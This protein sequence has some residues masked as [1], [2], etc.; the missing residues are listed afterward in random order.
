M[1]HDAHAPTRIEGRI[2]TADPAR[3]WAASVEW[4]DGAVVAVDAPP[5]PGART[6]RLPPAHVALPGLIDAHLHLTLGALTLAQ[7]DL[8]RVRSRAEFERAVADA[9]R[10]LAPG[11]WLRAH[12]WHEANW[13]GER[14]TRAWLAGA[15]DVPCVAYRMDHHACVVN[16]PVL[17]RIA[18]V[19][20]PEGGEVVR[21]AGGAPTGL[22]LEQAAW[23]LV[24]P[25]VPEPPAADRREA[26]LRAHAHCNAFGITAVGSMEYE[27]DLREVHVPLGERLGAARTLR[28]LATILDRDW[29]VDRAWG[30]ALRPDGHLRVAGWKQFIDGTLGSRTAR[31]LEPYSDDAG[32]RG[33]LVETAAE[34]R[35]RLREWARETV[36]LG[37][38][39]SMH[40]IGDEAMRVALDAVD[41]VDPARVAR[42]EHCQTLD[43]ADLA[44][45]RGRVASMQPLHKADDAR[46]AHA[47]L[48]EARMRSFFRFRDL[49]DAGARLAFGSD[50]PIVSCDPRL[51]IRAAVTGLDLDGRP[52]RIDQN[53]TVGESLAAYTRGAAD[54]LRAPDL[55]MLAPGRAADLCVLAAD[56]FA[57]DW[58]GG[59][60]PAVA[61]TVVAGRE[62]HG[63]LA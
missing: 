15:G 16:D 61:A 19:P 24:N 44:R 58:H 23:R 34:S 35:D 42:F 2:W 50:W 59:A 18:G 17:A 7:L 29:P 63:A 43:D 21:D 31:M 1:T 22:L 51:G 45:M 13:G 6:V 38:S 9:A 47:R 52:C 60:L 28:V 37:F 40:A 12:G 33:M 8:S 62:V 5:S 55:G 39:P 14:P 53:L 3:P 25:I 26:V 46:I 11:R 36:E 56:P 41:P 30:R 32:N 57:W 10:T 4:R 49:A 20:C 54:A 27:R 48:G